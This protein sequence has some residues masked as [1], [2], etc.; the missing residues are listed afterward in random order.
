MTRAKPRH[1]SPEPKMSYGFPDGADLHLRDIRDSMDV[2]GDLL[3]GQASPT[4]IEL[5][6][7][8]LASLMRVL[9]ARMGDVIKSAEFGKL[10]VLID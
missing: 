7:R 4:T 9:S 5:D 2:V 8:K 3:D 1:F 10:H 6:E